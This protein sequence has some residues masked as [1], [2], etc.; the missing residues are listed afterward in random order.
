[1]ESRR[2]N[3]DDAL[4]A[5]HLDGATTEQESAEVRS[6]IAESAK[7]RAVYD[8]FKKIWFKSQTAAGTSDLSFDKNAAFQKVLDR[9][10]KQQDSEELTVPQKSAKS[11]SLVYYFA[12]IAAVLFLGIAIYLIYLNLVPSDAE[13][14]L[15][16]T[17]ESTETVLADSSVINLNAGGEIKYAEN[18]M[19]NRRL[20]LSGEAFFEVKKHSDK[21]FIV[22]TND[23]DVTVL[24]TSFYVK[25][26]ENDS[27]IEV[28]VKTGS[29]QVAQRNGEKSIILEA[30][31]MTKYNSTSRE[32]SQAEKYDSNTLFWKTAVLE[33]NGQPLDQVLSTLSSVYDVQI[34]FQESALE[35]CHFTGR[36]K[37]AAIEEILE[38]LQMSFNIEVLMNDEI[39]ITGNACEQ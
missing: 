31:E 32:F 35:N 9:I 6:W 27:I 37:D 15:R 22:Q 34:A 16:A 30:N 11:F 14:Q 12:R 33:F 18:F 38:Q 2:N 17:N 10:E 23:L 4:L 3:I 36:F 13:L 21:S 26:F 7:N 25:A 8:Q 20:S 39:V 29:V 1:M 28:G 24:G 19:D 5:K